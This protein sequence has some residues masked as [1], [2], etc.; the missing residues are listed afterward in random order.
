MRRRTCLDRLNRSFTHRIL[1]LEAVANQVAGKVGHDIDRALAF[2]TIEA[3]TSWSN[4][5]R[6]FYLSCPFAYPKT[7]GGQHVSHNDSTIVDERHALLRSI[8]V[9]KGNG[10]SY[11]RAQTA[12]YISFSDEPV[13]REKR[14]LSKLASDLL[15]TNTSAVTTGL[16]Y[17]TTFF[18]DLPIIRN[19]YAHRSHGTATKVFSMAK[20][21][22]GAVAIHHPSELVNV[23]LAGSTQTMIQEWL[24]D[25]KQIGYSICK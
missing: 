14:C 22:Y 11:S 23:V 2:L 25:M 4:F 16:S 17:Q 6:E 9:L 18:D 5:T 12:G 1:R 13:W 21:K 7:I 3:L 10:H 8:L 20:T 15:L 24:G 19:F